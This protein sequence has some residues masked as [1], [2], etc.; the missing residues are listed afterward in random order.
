MER[1]DDN[2]LIIYTDGSCKERPRRGGYAYVLVWTSPDGKEQHHPHQGTGKLG[3]KIGEMELT[4]CVEALRYATSRHCP[5]SDH[6]K[7]VVFSDAQFLVDSANGGE[8]RWKQS[9]WMTRELEPVKYPA[10]WQELFKAKRRAGRVE[11]KKVAAHKGNPFNELADTLAKQ[12]AE[13]AIGTRRGAGVARRKLSKAPTEPRSV[14]M[15]GQAETIR[16]VSVDPISAQYHC[17]RYE[18]VG[19]ESGDLGKVDEAFALNHKVVMRGA[20]TYEVRFAE[21]G[22]GRWIREVIRE[23]DPE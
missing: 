12:S 19:E 10:L 14:A 22:K 21:G 1:H 23:V 6:E 7:I 8:S 4:A 20:H 3:A 9:G 17:Y 16:I 15:E 2:A 5:A 11:F 13:S 18:V